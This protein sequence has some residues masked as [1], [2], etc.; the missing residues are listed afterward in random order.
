LAKK[1]AITNKQRN[2]HDYFFIFRRIED[3][4]QVLDL[5]APETLR[6]LWGWPEAWVPFSAVKEWRLKESHASNAD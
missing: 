3:K 6:G 2:L 5:N 1:Y 4:H